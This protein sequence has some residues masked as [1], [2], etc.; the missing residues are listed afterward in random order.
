MLRLGKQDKAF[1]IMIRERLG[2]KWSYHS[3]RREQRGC[4]EKLERE[5]NPGE[6]LRTRI[7][8][9]DKENRLDDRDERKV[10]KNRIGHSYRLRG[11]E[12]HEMQAAL[13]SG[14]KKS[15]YAR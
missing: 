8:G 1:S 3:S 4:G 13:F 14:G 7:L 6:D 10:I 2:G 12:E 9:R 5:G 15:A 11:P